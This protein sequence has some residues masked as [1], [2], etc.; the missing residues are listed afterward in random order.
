M[1]LN[2]T[3][4]V[5]VNSTLSR[6]H[7]YNKEI[8]ANGTKIIPSDRMKFLGVTID[9]RLNFNLANVVSK[10]DSRLFLM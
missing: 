5:L 7:K 4:T 3:K 9:N 1:L 6:K 2:T 8:L 10:C